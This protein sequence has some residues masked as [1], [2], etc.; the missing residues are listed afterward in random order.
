MEAVASPVADR[1]EVGELHGTGGLDDDAGRAPDRLE[2][3]P[4][5]VAVGDR[6]READEGDVGR[7]VEDD[8]LPHRA[9]ERVLEVVDLVE[10]GD[11]EVGEIA[12]S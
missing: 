12:A 2:P 6:G 9:P 11:G 3:A 5:L 10:H 8:L 4:D 1:V 7:E